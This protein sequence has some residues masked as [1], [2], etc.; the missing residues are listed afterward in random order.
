MAAKILIVDDDAETLRLVS[1]MLQRQGYQVLSAQN[2]EQA[3]QLIQTDSPDLVVLDI[4][5]PDVDGYQV[6][7]RI[8]NSPGRSD[9]PILMF[10]AKNQVDDKIAGYEAGADDYLTKP[11]HPAEL[12]AH[13]KALLTRR[14]APAAAATTR[15]YCVGIMGP[16]GGMGC[17]TLA[18]NLA[19]TYYQISK[20]PVI[21]AET[22]SAMG[23]WAT[24]L[25]LSTTEGLSTL[26]RQKPET[27]VPEE[28]ENYLVRTTYGPRLLLASNRLADAELLTAIPQLVRMVQGLC[29]LAPFV[30]LD[31]GTPANPSIEKMIDL[32]NELLVLTEAQPESIQRTKALLDQL[33]EQ[34]ASKTKLIN[35]VVVNRQRVDL[36]ISIDQLRDTLGFNPITVIPPAPE[37]AYQ[38]M[39]RCV[40]MT[41]VLPDSIVTRQ[42]V[43][44]AE[45]FTTRV[46][47]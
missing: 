33:K 1:L 38:A 40:P 3:L 15:G 27:L 6:S 10:T 32:C 45:G 18:L 44:L 36:Q 24:T 35:L 43:H 11:V 25:N 37:Q 31:I 21:A 23:S 42:I 47:A 16:K 12:I 28:I 34:S 41:H 7:Q 14:R 17:S 19:I 22:R 30:V 26:L 13:I 5:M 46:R 2:G 4:M 20:Q 9:L 39:M 8:R 29:Q